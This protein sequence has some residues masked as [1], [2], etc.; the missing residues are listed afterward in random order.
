MKYRV[1]CETESLTKEADGTPAEVCPT[2]A[3]HDVRAGSLCIV[4]E[5]L[6]DERDAD[7]KYTVST[8]GTCFTSPDGNCWKVS[9]DNTGALTTTLHND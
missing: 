2:D 1:Y 8:A 7:I 9:V 6:P 5:D 3:S 4:G